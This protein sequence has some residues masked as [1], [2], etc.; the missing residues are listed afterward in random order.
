MGLKPN[1]ENPIF[2]Q[3][4]NTIGWVILTCINPAW[5]DL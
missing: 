1:P 2:P 5:Y 4:F 3:C